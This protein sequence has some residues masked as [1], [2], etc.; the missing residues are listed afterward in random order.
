MRNLI[1]NWSH[2]GNF[3]LNIGPKADPDGGKEIYLFL[4]HAK[5][6]NEINVKGLLNMPKEIKVLETDEI[7]D[8]KIYTSGLVFE[9]PEYGLDEN[10]AVIK[11]TKL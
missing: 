4:Y 10:I 2:G 5:D 3:Q 7:I 8:G 6:L 9:V 11:V 1:D